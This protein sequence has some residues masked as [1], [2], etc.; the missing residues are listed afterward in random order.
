[1]STRVGERPET[2]AALAVA[3]E[4]RS[5]GAKVTL[6]VHETKRLGRGAL[7]LPKVAEELRDAEIELEFLTG[8]LAGKHDPAGYGAALFTFF[9]AMTESERDHIRDKT[10]EGQRTA[11]T[12]GRAIGGVKVCDED[13]LATALRLRDEEHLSLR[14]IAGTVPLCTPSSNRSGGRLPGQ[15]GRKAPARGAGLDG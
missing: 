12:K 14:E 10:L 13:L 4:Y 6:V 15:P 8:P 5:L 11:R 3:R 2:K 9:A 1:M 7:E